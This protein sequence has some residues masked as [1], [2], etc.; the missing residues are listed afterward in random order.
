MPKKRMILQDSS[1]GQTPVQAAD[2]NVKDLTGLGAGVDYTI[3]D[4]DPWDVYV[5]THDTGAG[6]RV[7]YLPSAANNEGREITVVKTV[8]ALG[9]NSG[10]ATYALIIQTVSGSIGG[11]SQQYLYLDGGYLKAFS[12]GTNWIIT[13]LVEEDIVD[14][15][16]DNSLATTYQNYKIHRSMNNFTFGLQSDHLYTGTNTQF[17][18]GAGPAASVTY[19][20]AGWAPY[21]TQVFSSPSRGRDDGASTTRL[22]AFIQVRAAGAGT[23][24]NA[25]IL[26]D[27]TWSNFTSANAT[28][29]LLESTFFYTTDRIQQ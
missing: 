12:N 27:W 3:S 19:F 7:I 10:R 2:H 13:A 29:G 15:G 11:R 17:H 18:L 6:A 8:S 16:M 26:R 4:G 25:R 21:T 22:P 24:Y 20:P 5:I 23:L 9:G 28:K 1:L 14:L